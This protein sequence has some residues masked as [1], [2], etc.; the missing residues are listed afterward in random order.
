MTFFVDRRDKRWEDGAW[1]TEMFLALI[2]DYKLT[3]PE[4]AGLLCRKENTIRHWR[5]GTHIVIPRDSLRI[6]M[7]E[8]ATG[9]RNALN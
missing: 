5:S 9:G 6:L 2:A 8:M 1:R 4:V 7:L 3:V